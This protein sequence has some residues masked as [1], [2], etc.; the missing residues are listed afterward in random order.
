MLYFQE[1][2]TATHCKYTRYRPQNDKK[3]IECPVSVSFG[4]KIQSYTCSLLY[5]TFHLSI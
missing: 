1:I 5:Y 3:V 2:I 4:D